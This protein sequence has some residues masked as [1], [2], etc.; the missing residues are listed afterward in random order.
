MTTI[1]ELREALESVPSAL[2]DEDDR[3][4]RTET[5][6]SLDALERFDVVPTVIAFVGSSGSGKSSLVNAALGAQISP[7]GPIRPTT[8]RPSRGRGSCTRP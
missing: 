5:L 7:S 2:L 3:R 1:S 8:K 4:V 6:V